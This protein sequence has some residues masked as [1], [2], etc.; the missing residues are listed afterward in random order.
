MTQTDPIPLALLPDSA[1]VGSRGELHIGGIAVDEIVAEFGTP[2]FI[3][4]ENL[5]LIHI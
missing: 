2:L 4:D 1:E 3:Y 5:S